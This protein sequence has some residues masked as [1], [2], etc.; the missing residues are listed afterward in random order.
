MKR[1]KMKENE[2]NVKSDILFLFTTS[3]QFYLFYVSFQ[4]VLF[5]FDFFKKFFH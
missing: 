5:I 2:N 3:N 4:V 1:K